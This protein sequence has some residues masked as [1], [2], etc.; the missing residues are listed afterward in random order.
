M[1]QFEYT[2]IHNPN[3]DKLNELGSQGWEL[4]CR[5]E[6]SVAFFF[7][8]EKQVDTSDSNQ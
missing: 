6:M 2:V 8:R 7:K 1:K 3:L 4:V 5:S